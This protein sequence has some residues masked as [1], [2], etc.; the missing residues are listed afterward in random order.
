M[1]LNDIIFHVPS[2]FP[3][4]LNIFFIYGN[5]VWYSNHRN[6]QKQ[7][8][9]TRHMLVLHY[10]RFSGIFPSRNSDQWDNICSVHGVCLQLCTATDCCLMITND[11]NEICNNCIHLA[12][13]SEQ[14]KRAIGVITSWS[15]FQPSLM[16]YHQLLYNYTNPHCGKSEIHSGNFCYLNI[17]RIACRMLLCS[18]KLKQRQAVLV[19]LSFCHLLPTAALSGPVVLLRIRQV[20]MRRNKKL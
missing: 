14:S 11:P 9:H 2:G 17:K 13:E 4:E 18:R 8:S 3:V 16:S 1:S 10:Y 7:T 20:L 5:M 15:K 19:N 12:S 6:A